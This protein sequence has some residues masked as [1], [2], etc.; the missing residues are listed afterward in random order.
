VPGRCPNYRLVKIHRSYTV[1][2]IA[3]LLDLHKN[4]VRHWIK[5]GL[6]T[7]DRKR[8]TLV[9]GRDL[10][11]FL[12]A[13]RAGKR[14]MCPI[15]YLYCFRCR[16]PRFPAGSM[17]EYIPVTEKIGNLMAICPDCDCLMYRCVSVAKLSE[18]LVILDITFPQALQ[19]LTEIS[20]PTVNSDLRGDARP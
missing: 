6:L 3:S 16:S 17:A 14:Q 5:N 10:I 9:C 13:R 8:P 7:I 12:K 1:G 15:G 18:F 19:R 20:Q 4:T 2:G 11:T